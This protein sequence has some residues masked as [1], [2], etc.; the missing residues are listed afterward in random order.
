MRTF[1]RGVVLVNGLLNLVTGLAL[2]FT[3]EW[4]FNTIGNFPPFN[5]HYMGD[6]GAFVLAIGVGLLFAARHPDR[7]RSVI[8]LAAIGSILHVGNHLYDDFV[9]GHASLAHLVVDTLPLLIFA[10]LLLAA[11]WFTPTAMRQVTENVSSR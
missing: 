1:V 11:Y 9:A 8:G 2:L 6:A 3:P 5:Q 4:F 10:V 7:H